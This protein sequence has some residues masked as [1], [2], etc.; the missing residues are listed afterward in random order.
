MVIPSNTINNE[1]VVCVNW[2][3]RLYIVP[4]SEFPIHFVGY[5]FIRRFTKIK[6]K[7]SNS[8]DI[9]YIYIN[10][11][12]GKTLPVLDNAYKYHQYGLVNYNGTPDIHG[13]S[14]DGMLKD[15][16][17]DNKTS[18]RLQF[19]TY[20]YTDDN[21]I[22]FPI[23]DF[24]KIESI[25]T[26][27]EKS[28]NNIDMNNERSEGYTLQYG[29][30]LPDIENAYGNVFYCVPKNND[31]DID[32]YVE[33]HRD[34]LTTINEDLFNVFILTSSEDGKETFFSRI[35]YNHDTNQW[36]FLEESKD[37]NSKLVEEVSNANVIGI[38]DLNINSELITK[39]ADSYQIRKVSLKYYTSN[40]DLCY[41]LSDE[42]YKTAGN[43]EWIF[44]SLQDAIL[45]LD[46][47]F[48]R[49]KTTFHEQLMFAEMDPASKA[50]TIGWEGGID[51]QGNT[52]PM[53]V[54]TYMIVN[55]LWRSIIK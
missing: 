14:A 28:E 55:N 49:L 1:N 54:S 44:E 25:Y 29:T 17:E 6:H 40:D 24:I 18:L 51:S 12:N 27:N 20:S 42:I 50:F 16:C 19:F 37:D 23:R 30:S 3:D 36:I 43:R 15:V 48:N 41:D 34:S 7:S 10:N 21:Y 32:A 4:F 11:I 35:T 45:Y 13:I 38:E 22:P 8:N 9:L 53:I 33:E 52:N 46:D 39:V 31:F 2:N 5:K 47:L 26:E